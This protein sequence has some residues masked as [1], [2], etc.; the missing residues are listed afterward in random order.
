MGLK[1]VFFLKPDAIIRR[2]VGARTIK[3]ILSIEGVKPLAFIP[4][5]LDPKFLEEKHYAEHKGRPYF[6]WLVRYNSMIPV[7]LMILEISSEEIIGKIRDLLGPT[8][9]QKAVRQAPGSLRGRYGVY[10]G[11]NVAHAS[12]SKESAEKESEIWIEYIKKLG[13][14]LNEKKARED[15]LKYVEKYIDYPIIDNMRYVEEV[16]SYL[17]GEK[18]MEEVKKKMVELLLKET[19]EEFRKRVDLLENLAEEILI[20][21]KL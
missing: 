6:E 5:K 20:N 3:E 4:L 13:Y 7:I 14:E 16:E 18:S 19:D 12:D 10:G 21:A 2:Y 1:M 8:L 17:R 9:V 11:A 15:A